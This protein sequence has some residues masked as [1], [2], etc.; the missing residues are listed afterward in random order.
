[1]GVYTVMNDYSSHCVKPAESSHKRTAGFD[2][3]RGHPHVRYGFKRD[4]CPSQSP[5]LRAVT[6]P[7][8]EDAVYASPVYLLT[9][10]ERTRL[11]SRC[12]DP[13]A[14]TGSCVGDNIQ[15]DCQ[16]DNRVVYPVFVESDEPRHVGTDDVIS[17]MQRFVRE[18]LSVS[19]HDCGWFFSGGKSMHAHVPEF[20]RGHRLPELRDRA[21]EYPLLDENIYS[22]KRQFRLPGVIHSAGLP[23][24][25]IKPEWSA[26]R[27]IQEATAATP[28]RPDTYWAVIED[29]FT[30]PMAAIP[31]PNGEDPTA[32][33]ADGQSYQTKADRLRHERHPFSPY[34]R[35]SGGNRS[36]A[37]VRVMGPVIDTDDGR[38]AV[39][40]DI[41]GAIGCDGSYRVF[42]N[43]EPGVKPVYRP[44]LLSERDRTKWSHNRGDL[45]V[46][47]GGRSRQSRLVEPNVGDGCTAAVI[48]AENGRDETLDY[49]SSCGYETGGSHT[50]TETPTSPTTGPTRAERLQRKA[51]R[52]GDFPGLP[53]ADQLRIGNRLLQVRGWDGAIAWF[54]QHHPTFDRELCVRELKSMADKYD[55]LPSQ[56]TGSDHPSE[57]D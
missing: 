27:I 21:G 47:I 19:P 36:V 17:E 13:W 50:R 34:R 30:N 43:G 35:A 16:D 22:K 57:V 18:N 10:E 54:R 56:G 32:E 40:C 46:I 29:T 41:L 33:L 12:K 45:V 37:I 2:A 24:V 48:L 51:E 8:P 26:E 14:V 11:D 6:D 53:R 1:M 20:V 31:D 7:I 39:P 52:T 9:D 49:L 38:H 5:I 44:V 25:P 4:G 15:N 3:L 55:D 42:H 28:D 23:K